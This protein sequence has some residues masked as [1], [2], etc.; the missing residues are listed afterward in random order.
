MQVNRFSVTMN[1]EL[2]AAVRDTAARSGTSV[3]AWLA[4]AAAE[5]LRNDPL[6]VAL[7]A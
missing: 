2:D 3:S 7:D 6:R 5:A 1:P 4:S